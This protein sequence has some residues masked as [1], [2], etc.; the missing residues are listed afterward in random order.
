MKTPATLWL[1]VALLFSAAAVIPA[2]ESDPAFDPLGLHAD[3]PKL[4]RIQVEFIDVPHTTLTRLLAEPALSA[5]HTQLRATLADLAGKGEATVVETMLVTAR[6]GHK[7]TSES[8]KEYIYPTEY[9]SPEITTRP[10]PDDPEKLPPIST[11]EAVG[12]TPT[13]FETRNLGSTLEVEPT[14]DETGKVVDLRF[15]PELVYHT[16]DN[17]WAEWKDKRGDSSVRMPNIYCARINTSVLVVAGQPLFVAA[18]SP[19]NA[20][21]IPDTTRKLMVFVRCDVLTVGR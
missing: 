18:L 12:Y 1:A 8:I 19:K 3:L 6:S 15:V 2:Q 10:N 5:N 7:A 9:E 11:G 16:G 21:G 14:L 4:I 20:E 17:T 13:A